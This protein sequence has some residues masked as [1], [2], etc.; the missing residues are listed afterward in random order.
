MFARM[1]RRFSGFTL[2]EL[3][4]VI[5]IIGILVALLL[6]AV[7]AA[8]ES[9]RRTQ[10]SNQLK[11]MGLAILNHENTLKMFPTGGRHSWPKVENN[12]VN[13][14]PVGPKKQEMSVFYQILPYLEQGAVTGLTTTEAVIN[15]PIEMYFCPSRRQPTRSTET[16]RADE[17]GLGGHWLLDYCVVAPGPT[18][19]LLG[20]D[21][22]ARVIDKLRGCKFAAG[23]DGT[24]SLLPGDV[25]NSLPKVKGQPYLGFGGV[26]VRTQLERESNGTYR[27]HGDDAPTT[28]RKIQDGA[29]N[30]VMISEKRIPEDYQTGFGGVTGALPYD[31]RGWS[32]G[33]DPDTVG[34]SVCLLASDSDYSADLIAEVH[35]SNVAKLTIGSSHTAGV[36]AVFAD[37]S[38]RFFQ[39]GMNIETMNQLAHKSDGEII[40]TE[41]L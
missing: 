35:E 18:R 6:P 16:S 40:N 23:V 25:A 33:W 2:V 22:Q 41:E 4:V 19:S 17:D 27:D 20:D 39:F 24:Y 31:D 13:G 29:S 5:A 32:A 26:I 10:C 3:L 34:S 21:F 11:Q 30:T 12:V 1:H 36:N 14:K 38:V 15:T 28:F 37:G 8:R 7:Q 9:A